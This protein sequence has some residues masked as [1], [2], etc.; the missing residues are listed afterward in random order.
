MSDLNVYTQAIISEC[1][2]Q[3]IPTQ[4]ISNGT[5][6]EYIDMMIKDII[7]PHSSL[8]DKNRILTDLAKNRKRQCYRKVSID[9][10]ILNN[11]IKANNVNSKPMEIVINKDNVDN[12]TGCKI[13]GNLPTCGYQYSRGRILPYSEGFCCPCEVSN[14]NRYHVRGGQDCM[15]K[16]VLEDNLNYVKEEDKIMKE[17]YYS[18]A[19]C[20]FFNGLWYAVYE[21]EEP[22]LEQRIYVNIYMKPGKFSYASSNNKSSND[23]YLSNNDTEWIDLTEDKTLVLNTKSS[24]IKSKYGSKVEK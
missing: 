21:I 2:G 3:L 15:Q 4:E 19:H 24:V 1:K 5:R 8:Q 23:K 22:I 16:S 12:Y 10:K 14:G 7:S 6:D 11:N 17:T 20:M 13:S 9:V 18:S